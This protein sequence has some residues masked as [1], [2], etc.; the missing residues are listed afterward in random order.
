MYCDL[1]DDDPECLAE[2]ETIRNGRN[3]NYGL[4]PL[5]LKY[6]VDMYFAGHT[7]HYQREW[8]VARGAAVQ[9]S[10]LEPRAPVHIQSG[11]AGVDGGEAFPPTRRPYTAYRDEELNIGFSRLIF[12]NRTHLTFQQLFAVNGTVLDTFTLVQHNHGPFSEARV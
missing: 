8:P 9:Q 1:A 11:I 3:G 12:H 7:H 4:E 5:M 10:Y 2:A 6:G